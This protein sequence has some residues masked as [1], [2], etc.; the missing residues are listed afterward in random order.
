MALQQLRKKFFVDG[1]FAALQFGEFM[2]VV[3]D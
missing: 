3:I 2:L 1:A